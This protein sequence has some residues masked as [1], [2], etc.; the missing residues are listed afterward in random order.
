MRPGTRRGGI[1]ATRFR[2]PLIE[3]AA[4][5]D[6]ASTLESRIRIDLAVLTIPTPTHPLRT[7]HRSYWDR[8]AAPQLR[9]L[10]RAPPG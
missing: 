9:A 4:G 7:R 6:I 3:C 1:F 5:A 2:A 8:V 10:E